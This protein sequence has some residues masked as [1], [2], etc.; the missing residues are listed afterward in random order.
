MTFGFYLFI[1]DFFLVKLGKA[2]VSLVLENLIKKKKKKNSNSFE[3]SDIF[4]KLVQVIICQGKA[5]IQY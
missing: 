4:W 3:Y 1:N 2:G 5:S